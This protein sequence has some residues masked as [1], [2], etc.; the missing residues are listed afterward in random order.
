MAFV[1]VEFSDDENHEG[2]V[3]LVSKQWLTPRK[4]EVYWP[5]IKSQKKFDDTLKKGEQPDESEWTL[6]SIKRS[7]FEEGNKINYCK[8][9]SF[10]STYIFFSNR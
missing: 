3:A 8:P 10:V 2:G 5:P 4:K 9:E 1:G 7:F 6:Y